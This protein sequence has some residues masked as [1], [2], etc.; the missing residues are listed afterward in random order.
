[1]KKL[2]FSFVFCFVAYLV[3]GQQN[4][5]VHNNTSYNLAVR[6]VYETDSD[7]CDAGYGSIT[8]SPGTGVIYG[9]YN[10]TGWTLVEAYVSGSSPAYDVRAYSTCGAGCSLGTPVSNGLT[11]TWNGCDEVTIDD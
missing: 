5:I 6:G 10:T 11:A 4:L 9:V 7:K 8:L 1:M 3:N 2:I